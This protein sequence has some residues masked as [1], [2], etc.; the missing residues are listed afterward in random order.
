MTDNR[1]WMLLA[2]YDFG[3]EADFAEAMLKG[4]GIPV[5]VKGREAGIWGPGFAGPT[6]QGLSVWVPQTQVEEAREL[7]QPDSEAPVPEAG[8]G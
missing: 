8:E 5:V 7:L 4:A 3:Y 6:S 1:E 2:S